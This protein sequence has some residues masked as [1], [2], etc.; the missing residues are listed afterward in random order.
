MQFIVAINDRLEVLKF[1]E[2]SEKRC[3]LTIIDST[4]IKSDTI[5]LAFEILSCAIKALAMPTT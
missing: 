4:V 3:H 1:A 2:R 5:D